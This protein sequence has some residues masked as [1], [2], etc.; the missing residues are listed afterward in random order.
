[1]NKKVLIPL[2]VVAIVAVAGVVFFVT[3]NDT[4]DSQQVTSESTSVETQSNADTA[5]FSPI[6]TTDVSYVATLTSSKDGKT[7]TAVLKSDGK[8]VSEFE[9]KQDDQE[10]RMVMTADAYYSCSGGSCFKLPNRDSAEFDPA[11]YQYTNEDIADLKNNA[12]YKGTEACGALTCEV[13]AVKDGTS[14][15]TVY[16]DQA[17]KRIMRAV[18][19]Y[20]GDK[21][22]LVFE[23]KPVSISIPKNAQTLPQ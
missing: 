17:T 4:N 9:A 6:A 19:T 20:G 13:W 10:F 23:Y 5:T 21:G 15:G 16:I 1:M 14:D 8:G 3:N 7:F 2:V 12:T 18:G 11:S 22:E